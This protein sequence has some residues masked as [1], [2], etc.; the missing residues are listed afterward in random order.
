MSKNKYI[1]YD[2]PFTLTHGEHYF[3]IMAEN[4]YDDDMMLTEYSGMHHD[5]LES[6][7]LELGFAMGDDWGKYIKSLE[8]KEIGC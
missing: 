6:A 3:V 8:I 1:Y 5:T 2:G 4:K 7:R